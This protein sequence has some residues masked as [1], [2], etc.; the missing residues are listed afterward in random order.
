MIF[1]FKSGHLSSNKQL[2]RNGSVGETELGSLS[3]WTNTK[4]CSLDNQYIG[5]IFDKIPDASGHKNYAQIGLAATMIH[6]SMYVTPAPDS[7]KFKPDFDVKLA[8][9]CVT[10]S[11]ISYDTDYDNIKEKVATMD[12][13]AEMK[14]YD[15]KTDTDGFIASDSNSTVVV[16]RGTGTNKINWTFTDMVTNFKFVP[17]P[18]IPKSSD[19]PKGHLG[20]IG[21]LNSVYDSIVA[22]LKPAFGKKRLIFTGHSLGA[23]LASLFVYRLTK[24]H[25]E[26]KSSITLMTFA[27]PPTGNKEFREHFN[28][29]DSNSITI[30]GDFFSSGWL[31]K[32]AISVTKFY[33]PV[34]EKFLPFTGGHS[35]KG[36]VEQLENLSE[37]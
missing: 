4:P 8:K 30:Q 35:V 11:D 27:C 15:S 32:T 17:E 16:F 34:S 20:F 9:K 18:I 7:A 13:T 31:I 25:E 23:A 22:H 26:L 2:L 21:S 10:L 12:L 5:V 28:D 14:I 29:I 37:D 19:S 36:Y 3:E 6:A 24:D 1:D 33:R